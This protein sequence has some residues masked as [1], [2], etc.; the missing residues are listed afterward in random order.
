[1]LAATAAPAAEAEIMM[2]TG[3][4]FSPIGRLTE[5]GAQS[6]TH[7][8]SVLPRKEKGHKIPIAILGTLSLSSLHLRAACFHL[9]QVI[10]KRKRKEYKRVSPT[11]P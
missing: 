11:A 3:A 8:S 1:M 5:V 7:N 4:S 10:N 9:G 6:I 2:N